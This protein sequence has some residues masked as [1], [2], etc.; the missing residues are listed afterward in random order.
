M[1]AYVTV[2]PVAS[3]FVDRWPRRTLVVGLDVYRAVAAP[4]LPFVSAVWQI[5]LV[6]FKKRNMPYTKRCE[7]WVNQLLQMRRPAGVL[8]V[9]HKGMSMCSSLFYMRM[10][11]RE[12]VMPVFQCVRITLR[13]DKMSN[14]DAH[15]RK[16]AED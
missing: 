14:D 9:D 7:K 2:A 3:A 13:P 1:I 11:L 12:T 15:Y 5:Y 16:P 8:V 6:A 10:A 4:A